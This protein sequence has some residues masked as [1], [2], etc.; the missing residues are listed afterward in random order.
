MSTI[1]ITLSIFGILFILW[2][3]SLIFS[4]YLPTQYIKAPYLY[5]CKH[6]YRTP[7]VL[8]Y[9]IYRLFVKFL[10][11]LKKVTVKFLEYVLDTGNEILVNIL[12]KGLLYLIKG[13]FRLLAKIFD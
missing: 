4:K 1:Q 5:I 11:W 6:K 2:L 9:D 13:F 8:I 3:Y 12:L 7:I 10:K